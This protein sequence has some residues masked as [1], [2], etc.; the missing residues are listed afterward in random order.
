MV[1]ASRYSARLSYVVMV[2]AVEQL[3][4]RIFSHC[5]PTPLNYR[6]MTRIDAKGGK[7]I[8]TYSETRRGGKKHIRGHHQDDDGN[9]VSTGTNGRESKYRSSSKKN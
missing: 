5:R 3:S 1:R 2:A 8:W 6:Y 4:N 7:V 9:N